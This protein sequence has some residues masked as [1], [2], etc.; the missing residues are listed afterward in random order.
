[1]RFM[2]AY[3]GVEGGMSPLILN[4]GIMGVSRQRALRPRYPVEDSS[5]NLK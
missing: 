5:T 2:N 1:V 3:G 4:L